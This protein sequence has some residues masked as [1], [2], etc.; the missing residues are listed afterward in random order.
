M[1]TIG[2]PEGLCYE[3]LVSML[4]LCHNRNSLWHMKLLCCESRRVP[5]NA[6]D[7]TCWTCSWHSF[8]SW[9][10]HIWAKSIQLLVWRGKHSIDG[11]SGQRPGSSRQMTGEWLRL[12][13]DNGTAQQFSSSRHFNC[14]AMLLGLW[15]SACRLL[16]SRL[17]ICRAA[18]TMPDTLQT[19]LPH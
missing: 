17:A 15:D 14:A 11:V 4:F 9:T 18:K 10:V 13:R 8:T 16:R 3:H 12:V 7:V 19:C 5:Q 2:P 6:I 1:Y